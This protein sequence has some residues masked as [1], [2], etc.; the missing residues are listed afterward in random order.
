MLK[1]SKLSIEWSSI[2]YR[3]RL[4]SVKNV[5]IKHIQNSTI[6]H[7]MYKIYIDTDKTYFFSDLSLKKCHIESK[8]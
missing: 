5:K 7:W 6:K 1:M 4:L 8:I 2:S 3:Y